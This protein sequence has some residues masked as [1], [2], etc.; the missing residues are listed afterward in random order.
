[1][2]E[3]RL[4]NECETNQ[5]TIEEGMRAYMKASGSFI[6][7]VVLVALL[8]VSMVI[9]IALRVQGSTLLTFGL[10][11]LFCL[12]MVV[13]RYVFV[14]RQSAK[15]QTRRKEELFGTGRITGKYFFMDEE[16][17]SRTEQV[18]E[19]LHLPYER[20]RRAVETRR[21]IVLITKQRQM[22]MLNKAGFQNG[23]VEDFWK[24]LAEKCPEAKIKRF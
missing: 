13:F 5:E 9:L 6:V 14:P 18:V 24:L 15:M 19:E 10:L 21:L 11:D 16:I 12:A 17:M 8:V 7:D 4:V 3:N 20:I 2:D 23:T 22:L 1:M